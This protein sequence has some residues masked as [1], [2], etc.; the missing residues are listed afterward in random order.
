MGVTD[1]V[2]VMVKVGVTDGVRVMVRVITTFDVF[3]W[4]FFVGILGHFFRD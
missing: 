3:L 1:E 4:H 2:R